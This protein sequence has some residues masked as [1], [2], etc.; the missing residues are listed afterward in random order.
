MLK[1]KNYCFLLLKYRPRSENELGQRLKQ[2]GFPGEVVSAVVRF[3]KEKKYIDDEA[4]AK[5]WAAWRR[6]KGFGP[7]RISR[8]L[9]LKG[10]SSG[11]I[12]RQLAGAVKEDSEEEAVYQAA[13]IK[14]ATYANLPE[15]KIRQ[16]LYG[17]LLRRGFP[18]ESVIEAIN[19]LCR[20]TS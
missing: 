18:E 13:R 17:Y 5:A 19:N 15:E 14:L 9:K 8:E 4:F 7:R 12:S 2:K 6:E 3:L 1:A 11:I 10:V 20:H 16:R